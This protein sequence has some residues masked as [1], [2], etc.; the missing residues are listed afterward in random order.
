MELFSKVELIFVKYN[1]FEGTIMAFLCHSV[2]L[3]VRAIGRSENLGVP[4]LFGGHNL[5]TLVEIGLTYLPKSDSTHGTPR[6]ETP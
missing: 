2:T 3:L 4:V 6:D 1:L 5:P